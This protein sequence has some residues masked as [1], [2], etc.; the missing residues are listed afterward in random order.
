VHQF[1]TSFRAVRQI[2][3]PSRASNTARYCSLSTSHCTIT[4]PSWS[5]G[6]LAKLHWSFGES[7][8]PASI[9]PRSFRHRSVPSISKQNSPSEPKMATMLFPSVAGVELQ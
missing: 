3:R 1:A 8:G 5:T 2:S 6:E 9:L 4:L 7:H